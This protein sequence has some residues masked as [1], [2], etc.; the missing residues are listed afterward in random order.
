MDDFTNG[1]DSLR[2]A[3][4]SYLR[5][6]KSLTQ[7]ST[8]ST[9]FGLDRKIK[10]HHHQDQ[11]EISVFGAEKYFNMLMNQEDEGKLHPDH[12]H[13]LG[14]GGGGGGGADGEKSVINRAPGT[15]SACSEM[16]WNSRSTALLLRASS[17]TNSISSMA[18]NPSRNRSKT[19]LIF[20]TLVCAGSCSDEKSVYVTKQESQGRSEG[21]ENNHH[22]D[23]VVSKKVNEASKLS[24]QPNRKLV[25][26]DGGGDNDH[27]HSFRYTSRTTKRSEDHFAFPILSTTTEENK[28]TSSTTTSDHHHHHR[29]LQQQEDFQAPP[30][31][32]L[33]VFGSKTTKAAAAADEVAINLERKLSVLTWDA[34]PTKPQKKVPPKAG[35]GRPVSHDQDIDSDA[36]SDLFEI[37]NITVGSTATRSLCATPNNNPGVYAPSE[38]SIEWSVVTASALDLGSIVS[39]YN[40]KKISASSTSSRRYKAS[41]SGGGILGCKSQKSVRVAESTCRSSPSSKEITKSSNV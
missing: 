32:S 20:A 10:S 35:T 33:E 19:R 6:E 34:I 26:H 40:E 25:D 30:R 28:K 15:P 11:G 36:S 37:E 18:R 4:F 17:S 7:K 1:G 29:Y 9:S 8:S 2:D 22:H 14:G 39:D 16:S 41:K 24:Q 5:S 31:M 3:S 12:H 38:A 27:Q 13:H 23:I 21:G